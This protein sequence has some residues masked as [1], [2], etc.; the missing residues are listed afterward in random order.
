MYNYLVVLVYGVVFCANGVHNTVLPR[1][2]EYDGMRAAVVEAESNYGIGGKVFLNSVEQRADKVLRT[3]KMHELSASI[4]GQAPSG[5]HY[6][7]AK[8]FIENSAVFKVLQQMP[9]GATLHLHNS[10]GVSSNWVVKNLT[11]RHE[12]KLCHVNE[13]YYFTVRPVHYCPENQTRNINDMRK[14]RQDDIVAFDNWLESMINMKLKPSRNWSSSIDELWGDFESCFDAIRGF[15]QYKPFFEAYHWQLLHEFH[16]DHVY[17]IELRVSFSKLF[18]ADGKEHGPLEVAQV[19]Q[20]I[21]DDFRRLHPKFLGVKLIQ[22]K[23]KNMS[24]QD[25]EIALKVYGNLSSTYPGFVI[26]FDLVGQEDVNRSLKSFASLLLHPSGVSSTP[27]YFFHAGEIVGRF[28]EG[29]ENIIDAL[30]LDTRRIGHGYAL[31]KHPILWHAVRQR[32][33]AIEVCPISNQVLGLVSDLRNHPAGFYVAQNIPIVIAS[34][35]PGFWDAAGVSF[36]FY[37]AFMAIAPQTG[38]GFLKQIVWDSIK[39]STISETE[40]QNITNTMESQWTAFVN[41]LADGNF[42]EK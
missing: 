15:L 18:D 24:D 29:D 17:F 27:R 40:R 37:Y 26:G 1:T 5:M 35:D 8:P 9:K 6:F 21:V 31:M 32:Q 25:L 3:M 28:S 34:D 36:D 11:Y 23:H 12:A 22:A 41:Q 42:A 13:R 7:D 19:I 30:L 16:R 10:A 2:S 33:V 4:H 14:E 38:L 39:Y 20:R